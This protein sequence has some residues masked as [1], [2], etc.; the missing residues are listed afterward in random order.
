M[1]ILLSIGRFISDFFTSLLDFLK[2]VF[3]PKENYFSNHF[4][5]VSAAF[6]EKFKFISQIDDLMNS[7][8]VSTLSENDVYSIPMP[9]DLEITFSWYE[10]YRVKFRNVL[11]GAFTLMFVGA[12]V[13]RNDPKINI[14]G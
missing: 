12:I 6:N 14:G 9:Y 2:S 5:S 11:I 8:S 1:E 10:P 3:V 13:K 7:F 4:N